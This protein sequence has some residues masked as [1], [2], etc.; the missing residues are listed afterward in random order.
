MRPGIDVRRQASVRPATRQNNCDGKPSRPPGMRSRS[1]RA[2]PG[3][4]D[5]QRKVLA[6]E[7]R[8]HRAVLERDRGTPARFARRNG[9]ASG[10]RSCTRNRLSSAP[11]PKSEPAPPRRRAKPP[12]AARADAAR[13][14]DRLYVGQGDG[15]AGDG[16]SVG[17]AGALRPRPGRGPSREAARRRPSPAHRR[18]PRP[19][20]EAAFACC[21]TRRA[22]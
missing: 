22:I 7:N 18:S 19:L 9:C 1:A 17:R 3:G 4:R 12:S 6:A 8:A 10:P 11:P 13:Q 16:R 15:P 20:S 14:L 5:R 21:A 2:R